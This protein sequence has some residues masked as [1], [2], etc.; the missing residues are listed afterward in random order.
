V[1]GTITIGFLST[2]H[3]KSS[4]REISPSDPLVIFQNLVPDLRICLTWLCS[5]DHNIGDILNIATTIKCALWS[6]NLL[7]INNL[8]ASWP[9][10]SI[11]A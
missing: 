4:T 7:S 11:R 10:C 8:A 9:E 1:I 6:L 3:A 5:D 2:S